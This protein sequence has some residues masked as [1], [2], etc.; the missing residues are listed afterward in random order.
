MILF[1]AF[2]SQVFL[3]KFKYRKVMSNLS[4]IEFV[5]I[6]SRMQNAAVWANQKIQIQSHIGVFFV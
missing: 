3:S 1:Y 5:I 2:A 6:V 4:T